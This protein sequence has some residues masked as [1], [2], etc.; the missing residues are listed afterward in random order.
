MVDDIPELVRLL[1]EEFPGASVSVNDVGIKVDI[2][3]DEK[4]VTIPAEE[5]LNVIC[6]KFGHEPEPEIVEVVKVRL[7]DE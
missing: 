4:M 2:L 7:E 6:N 1:E 3:I 5:L